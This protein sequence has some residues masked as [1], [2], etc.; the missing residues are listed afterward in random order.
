MYH[1]PTAYSFKSPP[2]HIVFPGLPTSTLHKFWPV[3]YLYNLKTL[4]LGS[5][6]SLLLVYPGPSQI[7]PIWHS[8]PHVITDQEVLRT[9][10]AMLPSFIPQ[11]KKSDFHF[12]GFLRPQTGNRLKT[13]FGVTVLSFLASLLSKIICCHTNPSYDCQW[14]KKNKIHSSST[15]RVSHLRVPLSTSSLCW[16]WWPQCLNLHA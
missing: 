14:L 15:D 7:P 10:T 8:D 12:I 9:N 3:F 4:H 6:P 2:P 1:T 5:Q 16:G 11:R 13:D